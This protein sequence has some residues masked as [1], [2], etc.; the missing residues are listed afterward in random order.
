MLARTPSKYEVQDPQFNNWPFV[1]ISTYI[2]VCKRNNCVIDNL[3]F[4]QKYKIWEECDL[5]LKSTFPH[6]TPKKKYYKKKQNK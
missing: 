4:V 1:F 6:N 3:A 5:I 2:K